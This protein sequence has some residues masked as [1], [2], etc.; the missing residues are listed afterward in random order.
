MTHSQE[1]EEALF[2]AAA[3]IETPEARQAFLELVRDGDTSQSRRLG[4][5]LAAQAEADHFYRQAV[6]ARTMV[7]AEAGADAC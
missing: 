7:A 5:L 2:D 3:L 1:I 6:G 4:D